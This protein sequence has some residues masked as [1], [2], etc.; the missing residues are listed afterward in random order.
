M[1]NISLENCTID[2]RFIQGTLTEPTIIETNVGD[3]E[4]SNL[5]EIVLYSSTLTPSRGFINNKEIMLYGRKVKIDDSRAISFYKNG[6][7]ASIYLKGTNILDTPAGEFE[8]ID[9]ISYNKNGS[10][11]LVNPKNAIFVVT[12]DG[13]IQTYCVEFYNNGNVK[14]AVLS[15]DMKIGTKEYKTHDVIGWDK[16]GNFIGKLKWDLTKEEFIPEH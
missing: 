5:E 12:L 11:R 2:D 3:L 6:N 8:V 9:Y 7:L 16:S 13:M 10:V 15:E 14:N 4:F 1:K